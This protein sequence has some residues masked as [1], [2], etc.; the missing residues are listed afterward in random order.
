[1]SEPADNDID[2]SQYRFI[3]S[4]QH[5]LSE[6]DQPKPSAVE[7]YPSLDDYVYITQR[8][9]R[10]YS[11]PRLG[12]IALQVFFMLN[13]IGLPAVLFYSDH[14]VAGLAV[15][16]LNIALS[17]LFI[18]MAFKTDYRR[19]YRNMYPTFENEIVRVELHPDGIS[20]HHL[21]DFSFHSWTN[22]KSIDENKESLYF[23]LKGGR[24]LAVR[25]SGFAYDAE[26]SAFITFAKSHIQPGT[27]LSDARSN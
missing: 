15:F 16:V 11:Q 1:M 7:F 17:V 2:V 27:Q 23:F 26:K 24:G 4:E 20:C 10:A 9:A 8:A 19:Y 22:V 5:P 6:P 14:L 3:D 25:K 12:R 13:A 18:P 21:D